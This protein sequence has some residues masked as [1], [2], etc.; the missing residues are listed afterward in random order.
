MPTIMIPWMINFEKGPFCIGFGPYAAFILATSSDNG[1]P[2][3]PDLLALPSYDFGVVGSGGLKLPFTP[4]VS[5]I[6]EGRIS[7]AFTGTNS[8]YWNQIQGYVGVQINMG[9]RHPTYGY[10]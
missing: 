3:T 10:Y 2:A 5:G 1:T 7:H 9:K 4:R 6:V 8:F